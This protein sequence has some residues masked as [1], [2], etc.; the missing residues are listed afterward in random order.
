MARGGEQKFTITLTSVMQKLT[1]VTVIRNGLAFFH[2]EFFFGKRPETRIDPHS[3]RK[4][5]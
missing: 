1:Q 4:I 5:I 2:R 3:Q